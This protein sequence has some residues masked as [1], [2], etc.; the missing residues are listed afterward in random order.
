LP[1]ARLVPSR[2]SAL[3]RRRSFHLGLLLCEA[4]HP[5]SQ[6]TPMIRRH[7]QLPDLLDTVPGN[8]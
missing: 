5:H 2:R 8:S 7:F 1:W 4:V 3:R 6:M